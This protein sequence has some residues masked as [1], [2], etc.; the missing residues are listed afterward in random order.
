MPQIANEQYYLGTEQGDRNHCAVVA[1]AIATGMSRDQA[2]A[3]HAA[4][5]REDGRG[6][7]PYVTIKL[8]S[9]AGFD[10]TW[11]CPQ[12]MIAQYPKPHCNALKNVTSHH[13]RRF[14]KVWSEGT[15]LIETEGHIFCVKDGINQDWSINNALRAMNIWKITP[16]KDDAGGV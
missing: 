3:T 14:P 16:K 12:Y 8:I 7:M 13:M 2:Y 9:E 10:C 6:V 11:V 4:E 5:G 15:Y 1:L